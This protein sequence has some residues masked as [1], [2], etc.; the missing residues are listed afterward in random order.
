MCANQRQLF[1]IAGF[2]D[3]FTQS[4][5]KFAAV[6]KR[7]LPRRSFRYPWRMLEYRRQSVGEFVAAERIQVVDVCHRIT[8]LNQ[9][10][11]TRNA[12]ARFPSLWQGARAGVEDSA[13]RTSTINQGGR[14]RRHA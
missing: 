13:Q 5:V 7:P 9:L 12:E 1:L 8:G 14:C 11:M 10:I 3:R 4:G 2:H 6:S